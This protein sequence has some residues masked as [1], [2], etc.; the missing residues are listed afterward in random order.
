MSGNRN[1]HTRNCSVSSAQQKARWHLSGYTLNSP[2]YPALPV[3]CPW[4]RSDSLGQL[5]QL[6]IGLPCRWWGDWGSKH[7]FPHL[8]G[9][10]LLIR[11][12]QEQRNWLLLV[13]PANEP[14]GFVS[15]RPETQ[16]IAASSVC[17]PSSVHLIL[18]PG[19]CFHCCGRIRKLFQDLSLAAFCSLIPPCCLP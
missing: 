17:A 15:S 8:P 16:G 2:L 10:G 7:P 14:C 12:L 1:G 11:Q 18:F 4:V 6:D 3:L 19:W 13:C 5:T 9:S